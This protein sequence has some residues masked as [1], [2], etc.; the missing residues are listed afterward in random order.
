MEKATAVE[1]FPQSFRCSHLVLR[2]AWQQVLVLTGIPFIVV[3][4]MAMWL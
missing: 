4:V 3:L 2:A 1:M